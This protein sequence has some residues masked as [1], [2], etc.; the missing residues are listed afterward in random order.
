MKSTRTARLSRRLTLLL[1]A[2]ACS[3]VLLPAVPAH[4]QAQSLNLDGDWQSVGVEANGPVFATRAFHFEGDH[5]RVIYRAYA[6]PAG[7]EPLF[8]L[9]V[10]GV[11]V[12]GGAS[13]R[14]AG[15]V[16]GVFPA[17][18]RH[19]I[20]ESA[21]GVAMF[22]KMAC[23]L[24][25]GEITPLVT[26][27]CGFVPALMQAMGEYDLVAIHDGQLFFGDRAGDLTKARPEKLTP[28]AL[29]KK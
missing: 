9:D 23:H 12:L 29:R 27:A 18:H 28:Y 22:A 10:G 16:E 20:A 4:A 25:Q 2:L 8:S 11:Y 17:T 15:A 6:D 19:L 14:V 7:K 21:A 26:E 13:S 5:W 24:R 3:I 1:A